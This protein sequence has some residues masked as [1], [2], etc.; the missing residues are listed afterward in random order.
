MHE[1]EPA[2]AWWRSKGH[3]IFDG[4]SRSDGLR[5]GRKRVA[6]SLLAPPAGGWQFS[7]WWHFRVSSRSILVLREPSLDWH[8]DATPGGAADRCAGAVRVAHCEVT[9]ANRSNCATHQS[10]QPNGRQAE[11]PENHL[12]SNRCSASASCAAR[13]PVRCSALTSKQ[14]AS[15]SLLLLQ[16]AAPDRC[17]C[18]GLAV[19]ASRA[20]SEQQCH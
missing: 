17:S 6:P 16:Q 9:P 19:V 13:R 10:K 5:R 4:A 7:G 14:P 8:H 15:R 11:Q 3:G 20:S 18:C 2:P 1:T 12:S